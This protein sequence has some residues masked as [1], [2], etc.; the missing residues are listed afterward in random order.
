MRDT[1]GWL[2]REAWKAKGKPDCMH[3]ELSEERSFSG[4]TTGAYICTT[5]GLLTKRNE[6]E[7]DNETLSV[8][9]I[10]VVS[11]L[12]LSDPLTNPVFNSLHRFNAHR[13]DP[14]TN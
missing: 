3:R 13:L 11:L 4:V 1:V 12:L 2:L 14:F 5:C 8:M 7:E 6:S 10:P 9:T